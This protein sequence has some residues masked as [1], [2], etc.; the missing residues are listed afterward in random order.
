MLGAV[1]QHCSFFFFFC[2][3]QP[4]W[5]ATSWDLPSFC[6]VF[7]ACGY[8]PY[9]RFICGEGSVHHI[10]E[11]L[12]FMAST[13]CLPCVS[14]A[15]ASPEPVSSCISNVFLNSHQKMVEI[16]N[17]FFSQCLSSL[18]LYCPLLK[19]IFPDFYTHL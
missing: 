5:Y 6:P 4:S 3:E 14:C 10:H 19:S 9:L 7:R 17:Y 1:F 12:I 18:P 8:I 2:H 15:N 13:C 11:N 16:C